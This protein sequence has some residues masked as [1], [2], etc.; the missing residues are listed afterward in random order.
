MSR[1]FIFTILLTNIFAQDIKP[2]IAVLDFD[3]NNITKSEAAILTDRLRT[4]LFEIGAFNVIE[5]SV[6]EEV[7]K[8]QGFQ[9]S[10]C[11]TAECA[12][13]VGKLVGVEFMVGGAIG[14]LGSIFTVTARIIN[15]ETGELTIQAKEDCPCPIETL[16]T[17]TIRNIALELSGLKAISR[18]NYSSGSLYLTSTP[19]G[20]SI[21]IDNRPIDGT[22]PLT[23]ENLSS[24]EH[25][26]SVEK[27]NY[28]GK[29]VLNIEPEIINRHTIRLELFTVNLNVF[30]TPEGATAIVDGKRYGLTPVSIIDL[31]VGSHKLEVEKPGFVKHTRTVFLDKD[32]VN[33][34]EVTLEIAPKLSIISE[35][36]GAKINIVG[37]P[38]NYTTPQNR[39]VL[40]PGE[41]QVILTKQIM[42][43]TPKVLLFR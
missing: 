25:F 8:E 28:T 4:E 13:E 29:K 32:I 19:S 33:K 37:F 12:V 26:V 38:L 7:L 17:E 30:S 3:A 39:I 31:P 18:S 36:S 14:K 11:T 15:V 21:S 23:I 42:N 43:L 5:R 40:N 16:L 34:A 27:G 1:I 6:M 2:N 22:T 41:Y 20:A 24:G 10:G 35:P 9:Q